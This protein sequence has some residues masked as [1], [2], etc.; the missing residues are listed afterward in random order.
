[1]T[2]VHF[3]SDQFDHGLHAWCGRGTNVVLEDAFEATPKEERCS[4]CDREWF[5]N[6]QPDW[7]YKS[8]VKWIRTQR[9]LRDEFVAQVF[10]NSKAKP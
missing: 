4:L 5:P 8:A 1:M 10:K 9:L 7:H 3:H 2:K 6:G